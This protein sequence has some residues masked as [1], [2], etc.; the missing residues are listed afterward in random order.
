MIEDTAFHESGHALIRLLEE[1]YIGPPTFVTVIP[2]GERAG[3]VL[4]EGFQR[5][6]TPRKRRAAGRTI[7]AGVIAAR[8]AGFNTQEFSGTPDAEALALVAYFS[9]GGPRFVR[10]CWNGAELQLRL[11]WGALERIAGHLL[12]LGE[13]TEPHGIELLRMELDGPER[14]LVPDAERFI[15]L[16]AIV[17]HLPEFATQIQDAVRTLSAR[18]A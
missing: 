3:A 4:G 18:V 16:L 14:V 12:A 2:N 11:H 5:P 10:E 1:E 9:N 15:E 13:L 6:F 7:A 17:E 8:L